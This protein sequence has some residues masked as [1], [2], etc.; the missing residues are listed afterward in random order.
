LEAVA[1][2][3]DPSAPLDQLSRHLVEP[4]RW[5]LHSLNNGAIFGA[6]WYG[7]R[8]L[9]RA[10][11]YAIGDAGTWLAGQTM[12]GT[13]AALADNLRA[14]LPDASETDLA[15]RARATLKAYAR[16]TVDFIRALACDDAAATALFDVAADATRRFD[17]VL[18]QGRG[19]LL[20]TGH[21]GNW[22]LGSVLMS[23]VLHQPLTIVA[24]AEADPRVNAIRREIRDRLG[25]ETIE[26][27]Q[28]FDTALRLRRLLANNGIVAMLM[29]RHLGRDRVPVRLF[30][31]SAWFLRTPALL[32]HLSGAP[33][34]PCFIHRVEG[35]PHAALLGEP[36][37]VATDRSRDEAIREAAQG[38]A[39]QLAA[40]VRQHPEY[41]YHFYRYWDA[42]QDTYTGLE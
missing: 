26:V 19:A 35:R 3:V 17:A 42:Q 14:V 38:F 18:A 6:T 33:L 25:V 13:C 9:P 11:S 39:D 15:R 29:D 41:W 24:M 37:V 1:H 4:R 36:I 8:H 20:V 27:R 12:P 2:T 30:D 23:R 7:V 5:T 32:G 31:R 16:D 10:V 40:Q 34:V 21:F 22:E 28:A